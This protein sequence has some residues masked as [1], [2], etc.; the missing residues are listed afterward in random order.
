MNGR[1]EGWKEEREEGMEGGTNG[2]RK[3]GRKEGRMCEKKKGGSFEIAPSKVF[4][5]REGGGLE[6]GVTS[7]WSAPAPRRPYSRPANKRA[8][9][10]VT[11]VVMVVV[12]VIKVVAVGGG[13][14]RWRRRRW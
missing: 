4:W 9:A 14:W 2:G 13:G 8:I 3:G 10:R 5:V 6:R 11:V 7:N 12:I 1:N